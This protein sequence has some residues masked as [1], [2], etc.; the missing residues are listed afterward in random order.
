MSP[1]HLA[2]KR[3]SPQIVRLLLSDQHDPHADPNA[4]NRNGQ[5]A[6]H[7]AA[8]AGYVEIVRLLVTSNLSEP[9]DPRIPDSQQLTPLQAAKASHQEECAKLIEEYQQRFKPDFQ[10][11]APISI[12]EPVSAR[13]N[14]S[15]SMTPAANLEHDHDETT[16]D[17]ESTSMSTSKPPKK[18]LPQRTKRGSDQWS[19]DNGPS[20]D[21]SKSDVQQI[22]ALFKNNLTRPEEP[23]KNPPSVIGQ[24]LTNN[25]LQKKPKN[26]PVTGE[27]CSRGQNSLGKFR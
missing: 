26:T 14:S 3:N 20:F 12:N 15:I 18:S 17:D 25:P 10:R 7:Y 4:T 27:F 8:S 9:C 23:K 24:L 11:Q 21:Q 5:T 16:D 13:I 2:I 19:D 22:K 6:L 1:L